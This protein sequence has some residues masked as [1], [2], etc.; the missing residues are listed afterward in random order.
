MGVIEKGLLA[1]GICLVFVLAAWLVGFWLR[2]VSAGMTDYC[3]GCGSDLGPTRVKS[4]GHDFCSTA[5]VPAS[6]RTPRRTA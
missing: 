5:C 2:K 3:Q 1:L 4:N 6:W